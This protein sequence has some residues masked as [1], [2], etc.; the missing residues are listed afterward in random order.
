MRGEG[1]IID[2]KE[3]YKQIEHDDIT[4]DYVKEIKMNKKSLSNQEKK[5]LVKI[6]EKFKTND[7]KDTLKAIK[8]YAIWEPNECIDISR[9]KGVFRYKAYKLEN[10]NSLYLLDEIIKY[11]NIFKFSGITLKYLED[12]K[13][14]SWLFDFYKN[15][16]KNIIKYIK[17]HHKKRMIIKKDNKFIES[18]LFKDLLAYI[19][20]TF[21]GQK[22]LADEN[23]LNKDYLEGYSQEEVCEGVSYIIF[24]YDT[25]IGIKQDCSYFIDPKNVMSN[26]IEYIILAACK[27]IEV[28]EW[29]VCID[30]YNYKVDFSNNNL[31][32]FDYTET[33]EKSIIMG[34][35]KTQMQEQIFYTSLNSKRKDAISL[36]VVSDEIVKRLGERMTEEINDGCL[37][38]YRFLFPEDMF[39]MFQDE[40]IFAKKIFKE[41]I[42]NIQYCAKE[43]IMTVDEA[44]EKQITEH[45]NLFDI[46]LFQR[47]FVFINKFLEKTLF[48]K[49][50]EEK[51]ISSLI[52]AFRKEDLVKILNM[53]VNDPIKTEELLNMFIYKKKFKL[54]LQYTPLLQVSDNI[55]FPNTVISKSNILRNCIEYSYQIKNQIVNDDHG[56]EPLVKRC[57][58]MFLNCKEGYQVLTNKKFKYEKQN[59]EVDV[60]VVSKDEIILIEC[61]SPL[62]PVNNF[63]MR[64]SLVH[65][66]KANKQLSLSKK[67]FR[68]KSFRNNYFKALGIEYRNQN[69]RTCI[70]LGNRLFSG[71]NKLEHPI[72]YI[73]ELDTTL[74]GGIIE[75]E[76]GQWSV[77]NEKEYTHQDLIDFLSEDNS[78]SQLNFEAMDNVDKT[79][80]V[81]GKKITFKTYAY[82]FVKIFQIYDAKLKVI[83]S[84]D[85]L[86]KQLVDDYKKSQQNNK[87]NSKHKKIK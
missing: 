11:N 39:K 18:A 38:R 37:S 30:Y 73:Y 31:I 70:V 67:A 79:I 32:I 24:L 8:F 21:Y 68:D 77:W 36:E 53:F 76:L 63:E 3:V 81:E 20:L 13:Q 87:L 43:L 57:S 35:I 22:S 52:P 74:N 25:V 78:L 26:K 64:S 28:Q 61:K 44:V 58:E 50:D 12:K 5:I 14:L 86:K 71:Y 2:I 47:F 33:M 83:I 60:I 69:I 62:L 49:E 54:D 48:L 55:I 15:S 9:K 10:N 19:D 65:I 7:I 85:E 56:L 40:G 29:E 16:E 34:Y 17:N 84:N 41:E 27:V 51:I 1:I 59:G 66:E 46:L 80:S 4:T 72:R 23:Y 42:L 75:S 82:N 45:C 6:I